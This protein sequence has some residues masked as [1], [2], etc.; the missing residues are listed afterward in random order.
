[1]EADYDSSSRL[2][3][4]SISAWLTRVLSSRM[5]LV[6]PTRKSLECKTLVERRCCMSASDAGGCFTELAVTDTATFVLLQSGQKL[7]TMSM[8]RVNHG[9][10]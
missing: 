8:E 1:V 5:Q 7:D 10:Q 2:L 9:Q 3:V 4:S 6:I